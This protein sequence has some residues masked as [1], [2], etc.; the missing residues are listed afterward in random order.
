VPLEFTSSL[1]PAGGLFA[2]GLAGDM[3]TILHALPL[4]RGQR[5]EVIDFAR[6]QYAQLSIFV[7]HGRC[8]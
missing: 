8:H 6:G 4:G 1:A 5:S 2:D 3:L 7:S